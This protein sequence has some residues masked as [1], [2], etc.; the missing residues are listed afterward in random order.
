[1][2][3]TAAPIDVNGHQEEP[4][5]IFEHVSIGF[6]RKQVLEDISFKVRRGETRIL[7]GPAGVGKSV[8]LKLANGL[9]KPDSGRIFVFG[10]EVSAM[11]E[12]DLFALRGS[13]GTVFQEGALFDSLNVRDNVGF[14]LEEEHVAE[15]EITK[16]VTEA[17]RFVELEQAIYKF[18][19][20]LSGGMRRRVAIARAIVTN[21]DLLLYDSPTGGL[22]PITSTTIIELVVKQRDVYQTSSLLVTH[23]L[24][25]AFMM[26]TH[27]FNRETNQMEPLPEDRINA[28][29]SFLMLH[30][31]KLVFDGTTHDLVHSSDPFIRG[32][33][34]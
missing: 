13:I 27:R 30:D 20:E 8:L 29:T 4:V 23:R 2:A 31:R 7:L 11:R 16:R 3:G 28:N 9:L 33:I 10:Q 18:P 22:D 19:S 26:A 25:D 14:R 15:D 34:A 6:D 24:Q 21:P 12:E 32:Y 1:M 5:V 17:L